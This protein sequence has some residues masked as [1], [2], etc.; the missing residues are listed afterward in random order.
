MYI[1]DENHNPVP[2]N[3]PIIWGQWMEKDFNST[4]RVAEDFV[5]E[6]RISTVFLGMDHS[7]GQGPPL[8][9]ET[10]VFPLDSL[11]DEICERCSTWDE[12]IIQH[13]EILERLKCQH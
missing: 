12:A 13:N 6:K 1:L 5:G 8:L 7:F 11:Q 4:K 2:C 9:F 3:D 10:M